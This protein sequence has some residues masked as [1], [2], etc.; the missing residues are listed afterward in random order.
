M[1]QT[2]WVN[3]I[4]PD[5]GDNWTKVG[6][7]STY[8]IW[9]TPP[10]G[11][12]FL[13]RVQKVIR[14]AL[15]TGDIAILSNQDFGISNAGSRRFEVTFKYRSNAF[16]WV[17]RMASHSQYVIS[18]LSAS[19]TTASQA[20]IVVDGSG[21]PFDGLGFSVKTDGG[22]GSTIWFE[23]DEVSCRELL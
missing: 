14:K 16:L 7:N 4:S 1:S 9:T 23:I 2:D 18:K 11:S 13:T 21:L 3:K 12:G 8:S 15:N 10:V 17:A 19:P 20:T 5:I 6:T 22:S